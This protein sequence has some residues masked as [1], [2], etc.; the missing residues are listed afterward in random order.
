MNA[1]KAIFLDFDNTM[2]DYLKADIES[3]M[4]V[5]KLIPEELDNE[6]F[7]DISVENLLGFY[8]KLDEGTESPD[9]IHKYRLVNTLKYF[10]IPWEERYLYTYG[11]YFLNT[12]YCHNGVEEFMKYLHGKVK[13]AILTNSYNLDEQKKRIENTGLTK[14][15]DDIVVCCEIGKYKPDKEAFEHLI[16]KYKVEPEYCIYIGDSEKYDIQGAKNAGMHA[17]KI[18]HNGINNDETKADFHCC[19]FEELKEILNT[20]FEI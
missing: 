12:S 3:L 5:H 19:S 4:E 2:V 7:I 1:I 17:I 20:H 6:K 15:F 11:E 10:N 9:N 8:K 14:Y 13:L 16:H 18:S